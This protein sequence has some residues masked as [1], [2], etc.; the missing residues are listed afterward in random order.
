MARYKAGSLRHFWTLAS[1][2]K[3]DVHKPCVLPRG[4]MPAGCPT[5][6]ETISYSGRPDFANAANCT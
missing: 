2:P 6:N 5:R 3:P 1:C 4:A